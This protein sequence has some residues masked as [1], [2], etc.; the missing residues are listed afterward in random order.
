MVGRCS[1][2]DGGD[3]G[4]KFHITIRYDKWTPLK[5][6]NAICRHKERRK[7]AKS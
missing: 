4:G 6:K 7:N 3:I 5:I 2:G 1:D